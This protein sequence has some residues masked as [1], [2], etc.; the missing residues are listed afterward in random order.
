[1]R[2]LIVGATGL[3][4]KEIVRL[5]SSDHPGYWREPQ[6]PGPVSGPRRQGVHRGNVPAT[7]N[8]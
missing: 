8:R 2:V 6:W 4:G 1:M 5:L 7:R 3:L